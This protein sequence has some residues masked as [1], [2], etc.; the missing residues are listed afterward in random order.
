MRIKTGNLLLFLSPFGRG[1][2]VREAFDFAVALKLF[3][4]PSIAAEPAGGIRRTAHMD[5][6]RFSPRQEVASKNPAGVANF[7]RIA[8]EARRQGVL[9]FGYFSL[10]QQRKVTRP[11]TQR[12]AK[13]FDFAFNCFCFYQCSAASDSPSPQPSPGGRG[14]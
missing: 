6:R 8:G 11:T 5:V 7:A 1:V 13:A 3:G 2:G 12:W 9:S 4:F 14:S 10:H